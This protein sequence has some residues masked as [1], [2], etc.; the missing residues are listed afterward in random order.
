[1]KKADLNGPKDETQKDGETFM[2]AP[3]HEGEDILQHV[4]RKAKE[5]IQ[6]ILGQTKENAVFEKCSMEPGMS[7]QKLKDKEKKK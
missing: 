2:G 3:R 4:K 5:K 1:M 6:E 7:Y